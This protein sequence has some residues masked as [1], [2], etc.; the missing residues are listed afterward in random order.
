MVITIGLLAIALNSLI[1]IGHSCLELLAVI[2]VGLL[3]IALISLIALGY[4]C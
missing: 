3:V 2:A 1:A 4:I